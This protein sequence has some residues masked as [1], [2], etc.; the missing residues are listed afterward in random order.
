M[1]EET[2]VVVRIEGDT[3]WVEAQRQSVCGACSLKNGCGSGIL[4]TVFSRK[5]PLVRVENSQHA[6]VGDR[7]LL[8]LN[9]NG[10]IT[11]SAVVYL[12]P[13]LSLF[14]FGLIGQL[15]AGVLQ[16]EWT[17]GM[18]VLFGLTGFFIAVWWLRRFDQRAR[19]DTRF[20]PVMLKKL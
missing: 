1:L 19:R 14:V 4:S 9:E 13:L 18:A 12:T 2:A 20:T 3:A 11:G 8:G 16:I 17:D 6:D 7:V 15:M 5:S 10:L